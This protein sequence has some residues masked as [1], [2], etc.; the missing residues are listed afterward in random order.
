MKPLQDQSRAVVFFN[1]GNRETRITV[2][3]ET[4]NVAPKNIIRIRDLWQRKDMDQSEHS[5]SAT[6]PA[7]GV[8]MFRIW[9]A[10]HDK[11]IH[12]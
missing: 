5:L 1:R 12:A 10:E 9:S 3:F 2:P 8:V 11:K 6:V 7:H 4:L